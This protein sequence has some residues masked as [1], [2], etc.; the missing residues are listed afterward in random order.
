MRGDKSLA[1]T[2]ATM[3]CRGK[4]SA[5]A[6]AVLLV[7]VSGRVMW[8][9]EKEPGDSISLD[10]IVEHGVNAAGGVNFYDNPH[11]AMMEV[12]PS[13]RLSREQAIFDLMALIYSINEVH[14]DMFAGCSQAE[15]MGA[16]NRTVS[17]LPDS[18]TVVEL[19]RRAAPVVAM[20]GDGHTALKILSEEILTPDTKRLPIIATI[21]NRRELICQASAD[22]VI[23][24]GA[25]IL[26]INGT[27]IDTMI[28][29]MLTYISGEREHFKLTRLSDDFAALHKLLYDAGEYAIEYEP[30]D[31]IGVSV[32][33]LPAIEQSELISRSPVVKSRNFGQDYAYMTDSVN[34]VAIMEFNKFND[35]GRMEQ[36][37]DSMFSD[38]RRKRITNLIIDIR[39]NS[40][41]DSDVGDVLLKYISDKPFTQFDR[42]FVKITPETVKLTGDTTMVPGL[43]LI[44][45]DT[46]S[47]QKPL[48]PEQGHY[49][50]KVYLLISNRTYS[51]ASSFAWI[52]KQLGMGK[53]IGE[54][55]GGMSVSY[56]DVVT[57]TLPISKLPCIISYKR[58]W[59]YGADEEDIHGVMPDK[60]VPADG[61]MATALRMA[62]WNKRR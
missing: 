16:F 37:A 9:D 22:S 39:N 21:N 1:T 14:P 57:Y 59:K 3:I 6:L 13:G 45:T 4:V 51:S 23:P 58:F 20:I 5:V 42:M 15:L 32:V 60:E 29:T 56:G 11:P 34:N 44:E 55:T 33:I 41:G 17:G 38:L 31:S 50:G 53:V 62:G 36:F 28:D 61:A 26:S 27:D 10:S 8:A 47:M 48:T 40:G 30:R 19:Y 43:F 46:A 18:L 7:M 54:E 12:A 2:A 35:P 49:D 52:F 24:T 25:N